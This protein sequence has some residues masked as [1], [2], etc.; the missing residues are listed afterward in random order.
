MYA[1]RTSKSSIKPR[2]PQDLN[3]NATTIIKG[4]LSICIQ[5]APGPGMISLDDFQYEAYNNDFG[6]LTV[7]DLITLGK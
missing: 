7:H 1:K 3:T 6:P 2:K 4:E 5:K